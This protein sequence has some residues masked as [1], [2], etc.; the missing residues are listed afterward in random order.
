M[1]IHHFVHCHVCPLKEGF[2]SFGKPAASWRWQH[3][4]ERRT[5]QTEIGV[6]V[7]IIQPEPSDL[8]DITQAT[9]ACPLRQAVAYTQTLQAAD[10]IKAVRS[11]QK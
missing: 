4:G 7:T 5:R 2:C 1:S 11:P 6:K 10:L 9:L 3:Q 8:G